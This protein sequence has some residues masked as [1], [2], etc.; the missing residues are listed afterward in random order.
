M[1][2]KS[3]KMD[4]MGNVDAFALMQAIGIAQEEKREGEH[5]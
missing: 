1:G 3:G 4:E 2:T 5:D